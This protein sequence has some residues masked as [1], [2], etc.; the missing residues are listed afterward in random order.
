MTQSTEPLTQPGTLDLNR[1][2]QKFEKLH[3]RDILAWCVANIPTGL[4][5]ASA[6]NV[7]D[8]IITDLLYR[9]LKPAKPVPVLF[10]DTLHH[11]PQT[12]ELV[13][14]AT[15]IYQLKL[16]VY[17]IQG[18]DTP[19]AFAA[20]HGER[21]WKTQ[22]QKFRELTKVEPLQRGLNKL[23]TIAWISGHCSEQT[24][25]GA[26]MPIFE[27]DQQ[28]RLRVNPLANWSR[29]ETWAYVFEHDVIY[30]PL[31][32]QGYPK[33]GDMPLTKRIKSGEDGGGH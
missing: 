21:L 23:R 20:K 33:I 32:D 16:K 18:L 24:A 25:S 26:E 13:A 8:M 29:T 10:V 2:N 15:E 5:Q 31:H 17:K 6:F 12:L 4:V 22:N 28:Q 3:P 14:R 7:D 1:L 19:E 11:F 27:L 9:D 30:N